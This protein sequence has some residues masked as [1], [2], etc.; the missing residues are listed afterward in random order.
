[1]IAAS[2]SRVRLAY[3][4]LAGHLVFRRLGRRTGQRIERLGS[5]YGGWPCHVELLP[6]GAAA[7]CVGA[8]EDVSFDV[9]LNSRYGARVWCIDPT[10]RAVEHVRSLLEGRAIPAY[11][12]HGFDPDRFRLLSYAL[13]RSDGSLRFYEPSDRRHVSH[14]AVN[15]QKTAGYIVVEARRLES[16][17]AEAGLTRLDLLKLDVEGAEYTVIEDLC[18]GSVRP[19]QLLVEFE[20]VNRPGSLAAP[21]RISAA[22]CLLQR[23]GYSLT[24]HDRSNFLFL[25]GA[26]G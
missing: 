10:P 5:D 23:A 24:H 12:L 18:R 3:G 9:L 21:S 6:A 26:T 13:W 4:L 17:L 8:G 11:E 19:T 22:V 2:W 16:L 25:Y 1:V 20:E 7:F 14:S 15:L